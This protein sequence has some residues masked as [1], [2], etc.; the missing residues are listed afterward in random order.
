MLQLYS[1][2]LNGNVVRT[3]ASQASST[4]PCALSLDIPVFTVWS[5]NTG[6][7]K[8]L[9]S[10][11]LGKA[12]CEAKVCSQAAAVPLLAHVNCPEVL[13]KSLARSHMVL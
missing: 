11:G 10:A 3:F 6:V 13:E 9:V 7:G 1:R 4:D 12:V 8:S 2:R 5:P